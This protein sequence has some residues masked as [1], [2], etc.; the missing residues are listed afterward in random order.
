MKDTDD[1]AE[2]IG[3]NFYVFLEFF[4]PSGGS[5]GGFRV[6]MEPPFW[7]DLALRNTDDRLKWNPP[8]WLENKGNCLCGSP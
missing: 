5:R 4:P 6:S 3:A 2:A 1:S 8:P 7:L